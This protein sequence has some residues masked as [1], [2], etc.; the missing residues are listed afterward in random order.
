MI[1]IYTE[2]I[3]MT[4]AIKRNLDFETNCREA[5]Q[6]HIPEG[7]ISYLLIGISIRRLEADIG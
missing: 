7:I 1:L 3:K 4:N 2:D 6:F 5:E